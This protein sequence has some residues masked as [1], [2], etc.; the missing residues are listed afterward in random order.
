M[1]TFCVEFS[2]DDDVLTLEFDT[3]DTQLARRWYG[4]LAEVLEHDPTLR[5]N[6]RLYDFP[7][8]TWDEQQVVDRIN[9]ASGSS[10]HTKCL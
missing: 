3:Y 4:I 1:G 9:T 8:S 2:K 7:G 10:M 5:E 6:D